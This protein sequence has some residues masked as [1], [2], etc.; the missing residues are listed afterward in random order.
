[1]R[2]PRLNRGIQ[3]PLFSIVGLCGTEHI[4]RLRVSLCL[5]LIQVLVSHDLFARLDAARPDARTRTRSRPRASHRRISLSD[6]RGRDRVR[7]RASGL[8]ATSLAKK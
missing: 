4:L 1:M 3:E 8:A 2:L 6:A 5:I 7:V